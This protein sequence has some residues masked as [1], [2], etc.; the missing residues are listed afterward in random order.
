MTNQSPQVGQ[1]ERKTQ[2][3]IVTLFQDRLG[4]N[5]LG[6]WEERENN[7]NIEE[8]Y[9]RKFL[10]QNKKYNEKVIDKAIAEFK[11]TAEN[12]VLSL[13]DLN[14]EVY[15]LL[16]YGVNVKESLGK[17]NK[18]V[19]LIDWENPK[20]NHFA[21]AEEVTIRGNRTKRPDIVI[22]VNGIA[23]GV[24][25]L[26]RS[27][28]SVSE[29]IRQNIGN[30]KDEF[31]K[32]FFATSQI[33]MAGNDTEGLRY[34]TTQTSEDYY[35]S[36]NPKDQDF[37]DE[38][39]RLDRHIAQ[40]CQKSRF[41]EIVHDFIIFDSGIKKTCRHNQY[42]GVKSAQDNVKK[43]EGGIIWHTQGSGK[44]L[45]MV[46]LAKWIRE[47]MNDAR[48][49]LLTDRVELDEQIER[50]F[51]GVD[52]KIH[53]AKN[54]RDLIAELDKKEKWLIGSLVH[55]FGRSADKSDSGVEEYVSDL[56]ALLPS[57]FEAK[58]DIF[59]FVDECHRTHGG[60]LHE[61]MK[62]IL[63][64]ATFIGFT[65]TPLLKVDKKNSIAVWGKY[66]HEY[67]YNEAVADKV[68][69][70]LRYEARRVDQNITSQQKIDEW[71]E[72]R[73]KG[74][75][76]FAKAELKKRW[77]TM[78]GLLSSKSRLEKVVFDIIDDYYKKPRLE[79]GRG[80]AMLVASSI[81]EACQYY[82]I[83]QSQGFTKCA[84]ITS[85]EPNALDTES[86]EYAIYQKML[87]AHRPLEKKSGESDTDAFERKIKKMFVDQ[88]GQMQLLIVVDKLLTGFDAPPATYLYVDKNMQDHGLFQAICRVNRLDGE[89]K[90]YGYIID[91]R[92]L[93]KKLEKAVSEYTSEAFS[94][95][96]KDD[97]LGLLK[98][99]FS[100]GKKD[101]DEILET[102]RALCEPVS[103]PKSSPEY[104]RY[105]CGDV[106]NPYALKEKENKRVILYR[107]VGRLMRAYADIANDMDEA[108]YSKDQQ[109]AIK[110]EV[111][112]YEK[113]RT[114]VK[115]ASGDYI[116]LKKYEPAMRALMDRYISASE[117]EKLSAFDDKSLVELM[118]EKGIDA[119]DDLPDGLKK[120]QEALAE[121]IEN[122]V[123]K[124]ITDETPTNPKYY[125]RMSE[126]LNELVR[127]RK[128]AD[129]EYKKY[130]VEIIALSKQVK[131]PSESELYPSDIDTKGK[132]AL[133][134][135][136]GKNQ[137]N[138]IQIH[139]AILASRFDNWR[140]DIRKERAIKIAIKKILQDIS[141]DD[142]KNLFEIVKNQHE[143]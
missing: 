50:V 57:D 103:P 138:T 128:Q 5:Y 55:K 25:E 23:L 36:W 94:G 4:Y 54:G 114:E 39:N 74:L 12:Q 1:I 142:L 17:K 45:T 66:I 77:G 119:L 129:I 85:Y 141:E 118:A 97:V 13:Y 40:V 19:F 105:F 6:N 3:R 46:W 58:G 100:E 65:G 69:L 102:L 7:S 28:V 47:N 18:R 59:V 10:S 37:S 143:Y 52:E 86:R 11:K 34:G 96:D 91:Y 79:S 64:R 75:T 131:N 70:D 113:V 98:D 124:L 121:T 95:F 112:H 15:G 67:K 126:L 137:D 83:F 8:E 60:K 56:R 53:R 117:S 99:K 110:K 32:N 49:L 106:E 72:E 31:I 139:E 109:E 127:K 2:N 78:Q 20:N 63:P 135:N 24:I 21:I 33:L 89:D 29:G 107:T 61:A 76:D 93:F 104:I 80:N 71:F 123:R 68:V 41:L 30:Q 26:K 87:D 111:E 73:T 27:I 92:D 22:Y 38:S 130:L 101:L 116:N 84:V 88:P 115:L 62:E 14:K 132:Q 133:Y 16:R 122:N 82:E 90:D 42:F 120:S 125:S 51:N 35:L 9:L 43:H 140:G 44:S 136:L 48:V 81:Y 108:G 134:D